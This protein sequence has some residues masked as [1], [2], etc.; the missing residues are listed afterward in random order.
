MAL[1]VLPL[2]TGPIYAAG[3]YVNR[4]IPP[5]PKVRIIYRNIFVGLP[6]YAAYPAP[7]APPCPNVAPKSVR[8]AAPPVDPP[9]EE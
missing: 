1:A 9:E 8:R 5:R 6:V 4:Y 3:C 7:Q 2:A